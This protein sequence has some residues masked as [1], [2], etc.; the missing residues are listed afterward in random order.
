MKRWPEMTERPRDRQSG[1]PEP[2][3]DEIRRALD[4]LFE[5]SDVVELRAFKNRRCTVSGYYD[6]FDRLATDAQ[7]L[8]RQCGGVYVTLNSVQ[9]DLLARRKN[10]CVEYPESTTNDG[11]IVMRRWLPIDLDPVRP[12]GISSSDEE[13]SAAMALAEEIRKFLVEDLRFPEPVLA[14]SGNGWHLLFRVDLPNDEESFKLIRDCLAAL[15]QRF[16][17]DHVLVDAGNYNAS[18]IWKLFGSVAGKGDHTADRP[19]RLA[20]L[21]RVPDDVHIVPREKLQALADLAGEPPGPRATSGTESAGAPKWQAGRRRLAAPTQRGCALPGR[22]HGPVGAW[23]EMG[24]GE[25]RL[26]PRSHRQVGLRHPVRRRPNQRR[27][28]AQLVSR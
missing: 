7:R 17:D 24:S 14:N 20:R 22:L 9:P 4:V 10:R 3:V 8:N 15:D 18:R 19:H 27:L 2:S 12:T 5:P 21:V 23:R 28:P 11:Q 26:E 25:V 6:D 13:H 16:S 1:K